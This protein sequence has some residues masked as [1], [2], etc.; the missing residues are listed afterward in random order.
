MPTRSGSCYRTNE[1][2]QCNSIYSSKLFHISG[3]HYWPCPA[4]LSRPYSAPVISNFI[5]IVHLQRQ[6][7]WMIATK[8]WPIM[9]SICHRFFIVFLCILWDFHTH[10]FCLWSILGCLHFCHLVLLKRSF[11]SLFYC[12][13]WYQMGYWMMCYSL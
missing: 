4:L 13:D 3:P 11:I 7:Q 6:L 2:C 1:I 10:L 8:Y 5:F 12:I 9:I